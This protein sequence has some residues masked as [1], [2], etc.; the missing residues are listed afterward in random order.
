MV[1]SCIF[2]KIASGEAQSTILYQDDVV[3]AF[4]DAHP[5]APTHV[6]IIP[7]KHIRSLN[8][9]LDED[10]FLIGQ[11]FVVARRIAAE[12]GIHE[13]GYRIIVNTG[14]DGGQT[15]FHLHLHLIGGQRLRHPL[16]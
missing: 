13:G 5:V 3:T 1:D 11:M 4:R 8:E 10:R 14:P 9:L 16:G 6:L 7:N 15:V 2:C 12:E